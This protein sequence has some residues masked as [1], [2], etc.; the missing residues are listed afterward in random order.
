MGRKYA[1]KFRVTINT[2]LEEV[3]AWSFGPFSTSLHATTAHN[4]YDLIEITFEFVRQVL[5]RTYRARDSLESSWGP[6]S[7]AKSCAESPEPLS[8][9]QKSIHGYRPTHKWPQAA[10]IKVALGEIFVAT[11]H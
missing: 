2:I 4:L 7:R 8:K 3:T 5:G 9:C 10:L 11:I 6:K 1:K